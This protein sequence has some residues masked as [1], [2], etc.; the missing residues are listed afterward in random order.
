M[1]DSNKIPKFAFHQKIFSG[2]EQLT[3]NCLVLI[4]VINKMW[5]TSAIARVIVN[6]IRQLI[7][8]L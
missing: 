4:E 3:I 2:R 8:Q 5:F 6:F 1:Q 7:T